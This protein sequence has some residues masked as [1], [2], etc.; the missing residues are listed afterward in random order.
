MILAKIKIEIVI[1]S[2]TKYALKDQFVW[3]FFD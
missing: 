3:K 2:D 1:M